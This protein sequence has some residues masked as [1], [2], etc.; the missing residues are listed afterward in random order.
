MS[1]K[2]FKF[3]DRKEPLSLNTVEL[4]TVA[5]IV[6][7][8]KSVVAQRE[9][10]VELMQALT[11]ESYIRLHSMLGDDVMKKILISC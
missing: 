5:I 1:W 11:E 3:R 9:L 8:T 6:L 7:S 10:I 4:K 2:N